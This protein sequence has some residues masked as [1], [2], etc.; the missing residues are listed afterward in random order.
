MTLSSSKLVDETNGSYDVDHGA[1]LI[2]LNPEG[3][4]V[5][6]MS[7]PHTVDAIS[8]DLIALA[9]KTGKLT[10]SIAST[11]D[12]YSTANEA[13]NDNQTPDNTQSQALA[14]SKAWIRPA[15]PT[16]RAMAGYF[17]LSNTGDSDIV[18]VDVESPLFR[19][20]MIHETV[21]EDGVKHGTL[22]STSRAR[23]W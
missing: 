22:R 1:A 15:P 18:L 20:S 10:P 2:L 6:V 8:S 14:I 23:R 3:R 16:A 9:E 5:G 13:E 19:M 4:F 12:S 21:M 17:E 11:I 7:A